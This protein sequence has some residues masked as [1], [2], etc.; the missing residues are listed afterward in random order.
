MYSKRD[1]IWLLFIYALTASA[2]LIH[3]RQETD[4][5][6]AYPIKCKND[7]MEFAWANEGPDSWMEKCPAMFTC[8][9]EGEALTTQESG[10][11]EKPSFVAKLRVFAP[12]TK[13]PIVLT[14]IILS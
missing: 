12:A 10:M 1:T 14:S 8:N 2:V 13:Q 4:N 3:N 9:A 7:S 5:F 11:A 6:E